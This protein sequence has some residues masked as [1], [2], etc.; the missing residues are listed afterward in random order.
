MRA[1]VFVEERLEAASTLA[2]MQRADTLVRPDGVFFAAS[3]L[4]VREKDSPFA[5]SR[6]EG[7]FCVFQ[8]IRHTRNG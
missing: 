6:E 4:R 2:A 1:A 3:R 7:P 8:K 5:A